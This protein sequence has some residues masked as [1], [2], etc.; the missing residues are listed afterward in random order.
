MR[1]TKERQEIGGFRGFQ[2]RWEGREGSSEVAAFEQGP[3][4]RE[5]VRRSWRIFLEE[6]GTSTKVER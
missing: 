1:K 4:S 3:D 5:G 6:G 2:L